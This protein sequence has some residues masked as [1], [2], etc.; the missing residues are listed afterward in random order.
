MPEARD[1]LTRP[2]NGVTET[3]NLRHRSIRTTGILPDNN[4]SEMT[5]HL[6]P[7]RW[8]STPLTGGGSGQHIGEVFTTIRRD[9]SVFETPMT[10]YRR[11][12]R[13]QN[14]PPSGSSFRRG[15]GGRSGQRSVLPSWYPRTP[16]ADITH[17]VR[18]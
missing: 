16:L 13:S 9:V 18:V 14:T 8:R 6:T 7:F 4:D 3:Y 12:S 2:I 11:G 10:V 17:V 1:R 15:R 5:T